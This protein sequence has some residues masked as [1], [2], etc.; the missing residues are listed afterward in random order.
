MNPDDSNPKPQPNPGEEI[1]QEMI[2]EYMRMVGRMLYDIILE[3]VKKQGTSRGSSG[4][5]LSEILSGEG[6]EL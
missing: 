6:S 4:P 2:D 1:T 5:T 3:W